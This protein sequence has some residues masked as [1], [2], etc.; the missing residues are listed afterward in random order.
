MHRRRTSRSSLGSSPRTVRSPTSRRQPFYA[1]SS[2]SST[3]SSCACTRCCRVA[4]RDRRRR[5]GSAL[6]T[7]DSIND[8]KSALP[9]GGVSRRGQQQHSKEPRGPRMRKPSPLAH[10]AGA[11]AGFCVVASPVS[12][13]SYRE[14]LDLAAQRYR[15]EDFAPAAGAAAAVIVLTSRWRPSAPRAAAFPQSRHPSFG[16]VSVVPSGAHARWFSRTSRHAAFPLGAR[17]KGFKDEAPLPTSLRSRTCRRR[18]ITT[19]SGNWPSQTM[20]LIFPICSRSR[21]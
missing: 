7:R 9:C 4:P 19:I 17:R 13:Q 3:R 11:V 15:A 20:A 16:P 1:I 6:G 2:R 8:G 5:S 21:R 14:L 10:C 18:D 12:A